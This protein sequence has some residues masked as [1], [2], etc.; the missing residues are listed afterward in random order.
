M[1]GIAI[2]DK[3]YWGQGYGQD[4]TRLLLDYAFNLLNLNSVM[5]GAFSFNERAINCYRRVGFKEIGRQRQARII[6]G[7]KFD[8]V[9]MDMLAEEFQSVYV[10]GLLALPQEEIP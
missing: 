10:K 5:L 6:A 7:R 9:L 1:L 3:A 2:G 4:A 8:V